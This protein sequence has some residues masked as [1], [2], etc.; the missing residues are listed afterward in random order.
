MFAIF[1]MVAM[2]G[3]VAPASCTG[4]YLQAGSLDCD[5]DGSSDGDCGGVSID[6]VV[7]FDARTEKRVAAELDLKDAETCP[8]GCVYVDDA[9]TPVRF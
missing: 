6:C 7:T 5:D 4:S 2:E 1:Q 8:K 9:M 3:K